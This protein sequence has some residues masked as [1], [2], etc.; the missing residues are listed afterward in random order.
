M[1]KA[2]KK[3]MAGRTAFIVAHRLSTI[4]GADRIL[5][6]Q[7]GSILTDGTHQEL[8]KNRGYYWETYCLQ[9]GIDVKEGGE[10]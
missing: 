10:Q 9:N 8:L 4:A 5:F 6:M 3:L 1:Q 7:N 2:F